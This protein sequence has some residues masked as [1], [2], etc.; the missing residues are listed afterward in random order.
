M[1]KITRQPANRRTG[2]HGVGPITSRC[3]INLILQSLRIRWIKEHVITRRKQIGWPW[4]TLS[5]DWRRREQL[6]ISVRRVP[7]E[8]QS[9]PP[10]G[11]T[12]LNS[13][14]EDRSRQI[15]TN[16]N[17]PKLNTKSQ[18]AGRRHWMVTNE[19]P[20]FDRRWH[21]SQH[22]VTCLV[23]S[24]YCNIF[25]SGYPSALERGDMWVEVVSSFEFM[26]SLNDRYQCA[27][28]A[29]FERQTIPTK[30]RY[31]FK[32]WLVGWRKKRPLTVSLK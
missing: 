25:I 21:E 29:P 30:M 4:G 26:K 13:Q 14:S 32:T 9:I 24:E 18:W 8:N 12:R 11:L 1:S 22:S 2:Y 10:A 28:Q 20:V 15:P 31:Q 17:P 6:Y 7:L 19:R 5:V 3:A 16:Q 23:I 27:R